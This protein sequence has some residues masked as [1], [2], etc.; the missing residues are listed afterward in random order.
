LKIEYDP[1]KRDDILIR[2]GLDMVDAAL[3]FAGQHDTVRDQRRDYGEP[4]FISLGRLRGRLVY[5]AWT[6]RG[7]VRRIISMRKANDR[8]QATYA[9][10]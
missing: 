8:E 1:A 9:H 3:V 2:R 10:L 4:R 6:P 7:D 5:I